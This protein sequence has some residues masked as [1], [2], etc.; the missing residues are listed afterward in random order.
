MSFTTAIL[1]TWVRRYLRLKSVF[2][3]DIETTGFNPRKNKIFSYCLCDEYG[4][5]EIHRLDTE[6]KGK[7]KKGW[8]RLREIFADPSIGK[9]AHN[10][11]FELQFLKAHGVKIHPE[12]CWHDTML[13]SRLLRNLNQSH[14]LDYLG[15][16]VLR[17]TIDTPFGT[18][19]S[20]QIDEKVSKQAKARGDRYDRV[21]ADLMYWY[22]YAD[23]ERPM[24]LYLLWINEF[25]N[26]PQ[27]MR[28]YIVEILVTATS[29]RME[30]TG[31]RL[32]Y[33]NTE[34]LI[35]WM[36]GELEQVR[37]KVFKRY[38]EYMNFLSDKQLFRVLYKI[39]GFPVVKRSLKTGLPVSNKDVLFALKE[40]YPDREVLDWI[41]QTRSYSNGISML[42]SYIDLA[43]AGIIHSSINSCQ[44]RTHRQSSSN[45]N[46]QNVSKEEALKNPFAIP[47]RKCFRCKPG[48]FMV[49]GDYAGIELRLIIELAN[50]EKMMEYMRQGISPHVVACK[51]FYGSLFKSKKESKSLYGA[52]KN[53]HFALGYGAGFSKLALVLFTNE[54]IAEFRDLLHTK[55]KNLGLRLGMEGLNRYA[56]EFPEIANLSRNVGKEVKQNGYV[57]TPF[58][59]KLHVPYRKAYVGLN[60]KIQNTAAKILKRAE[61]NVDHYLKTVWNDEIKLV[62]VIHDEVVLEFPNHLEKYIDEVLYTCGQLMC[63]MPEIQVPLEIE[64]NITKSLWNSKKFLPIEKPSDFNYSSLTRELKSFI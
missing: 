44:A 52:G 17:Y 9:L 64:W 1:K 51:L 20:T 50:S 14:A 45:P 10:Y 38:G 15:K 53:G 31:I 41:I 33:G 4:N 35:D 46:L 16:E 22:Q 58:G 23:A 28:E 37:D 7:T 24:L 57:V 6:N 62:M 27:L 47:A 21:D 56:E 36:E 59:T 42:Q 63:D 25:L 55:E 40:D 11:K 13:M 60:Y 49:L 26:N 2:S 19:G 48:H 18:F 3:F 43:E 34:K 8:K 29:Q 5:V 61:V 30:S 39:E 54:I 12:T 32:H